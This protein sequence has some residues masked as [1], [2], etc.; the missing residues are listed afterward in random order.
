MTSIG[1]RPGSRRVVA[2]LA[3]LLAI[4]S[5]ANA[6]PSKAKPT[7]GLASPTKAAPPLAQST[8][9]T[10][11]PSAVPKT[12]PK[13]KPL[14]KITPALGWRRAERTGRLT[15]TSLVDVA[16]TGA[17]TAW[18]AGYHTDAEDEP[19][20]AVLLRVDG[21]RWRVADQ[22]SK[23]LPDA[24]D[25]FI[26]GIDADGPAHAWAVG[27]GH[28]GLGTLPFAMRWDGR[29]WHMSRPLG[30]GED[31]RLD[32]VAVDGRRAALVGNR[33]RWADDPGL[34]SPF[35]LTWNGRRFSE[36]TF[37]RG[38]VFTAVAT[39]RDHTWI[40]GGRTSGGCADS[41]PAVWHASAPGAAPA[42]ASLPDVGTGMLTAIWQNGPR[43]VWVTGT[44]GG[45][46]LCDP[47]EGSGTPLMLHWD[48]TS[49]TEIAL[50]GR[51]QRLHDM[52]SPGS[53]EVWLAATDDQAPLGRLLLLRFDGRRWAAEYLRLGGAA[54]AGWN[55]Y[56]LAASPGGLILAG[57]A[58]CCDQQRAVVF[59]RPLPRF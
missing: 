52:T 22:V 29:D 6:S 2:A 3:C 49:W 28:A 18:A 14:P 44:R 38:E 33:G 8:P 31:Q 19:A 16:A 43:D 39:G 15:A 59:S 13:I 17:G 7:R 32:D 51:V 4:T 46:G 41:R 9:A 26:T 40:A 47:V 36:Q 30:P 10:A 48:G 20:N 37:G 56:A 1:G 11:S 23:R 21:S 45:P 53:G 5:C 25:S 34:H 24:T 35:L 50:P 55:V 54:S 58:D 42:P 57:S 12:K 27:N